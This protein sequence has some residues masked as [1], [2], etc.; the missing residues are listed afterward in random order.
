[1]PTAVLGAVDF[2]SPLVWAVLV[3]WVMTVVLHEFAH[4]IVA[5]WGGD[6]TIRERGGLSLNPLQYV[7]PVFS[8]LLPLVF[9]AMGGVP[10]PGG[11]TYI[12]RDLLRNKWWDSGV[13]LA[14][15]AMNALLF[16]IGAVALH[17]RVGWIHDYGDEWTPAQ[18]L[19]ATLTC[20][21]LF[22][23]LLSLVPVPPLDGFGAINPFLSRDAQEK[24][25]NP[26]VRMGSIVVL[27]FVISSSTVGEYF[28]SVIIKALMRLGYGEYEAHRVLYVMGQTI[29]GWS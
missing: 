11:A 7:H 26:S 12:R 17:P 20:L 15:P 13:S 4:G 18:R 25:S 22:A 14:G 10:L 16:L 9:M 27:Y 19:V 8:I 29:F 24:L 23:V 5:Y 2:H 3:G 28:L 1:M 6:Y 21:Q